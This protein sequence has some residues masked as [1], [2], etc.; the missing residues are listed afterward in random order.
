[1]TNTCLHCGYSW[2]Q[3]WVR[4]MSK[5]CPHCHSPNWFRER[6]RRSKK[7][8]DGRCPYGTG[9]KTLKNLMSKETDNCILWPYALQN[10]YGVIEYRDRLYNTHVLVWA[11]ANH[12]PIP[13]LIDP[14][15]RVDALYVCHSCDIRPCINPRHLFEGTPKINT[16]DMIEKGRDRLRG[17]RSTNAKLTTE[18]VRVIRDMH[19]WLQGKVI[20]N[21]FGVSPSTICM[22]H[23]GKIWRTV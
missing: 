12:K 8:A 4:R 2:T 5:Q 13:E 16:A 17:E 20:A 9:L 23:Q 7:A 3:R 15:N 14:S 6:Q 11:F 22:L 1:M 18:D 10:G 19:G 21:I